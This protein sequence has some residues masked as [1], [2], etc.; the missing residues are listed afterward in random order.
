MSCDG[1]AN[2]EG[3]FMV[4]PRAPSHQVL[5]DVDDVFTPAPLCSDTVL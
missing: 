5:N 4:V 3:E 1:A 2:A